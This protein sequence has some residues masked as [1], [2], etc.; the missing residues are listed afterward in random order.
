MTTLS[1]LEIDSPLGRIRL[2]ADGD[3]LAGAWF[4]GQKHEPDLSAARRGEDRGVLRAAREQLE[5]YFAGERR[6]FDLPLAPRGTAFQ[7]RVWS[8]L[9]EI[10]F[11]ETWSYRE[12]AARAGAAGS[13]RAAGAANG[14]NPLGI[15]VPCHR[16]I[17]AS[18][19]LTG[20]AGGLEAKRWLL[21]H[22]ASVARARL[23]G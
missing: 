18:G 2:A 20:Y 23:A 5:Q 8:A 21:A 12:L 16:V 4:L 3:A 1:L 10:P 17:G 6:V 13:A 9:R 11:G 19:A 15:V 7:L 14:R 22:E